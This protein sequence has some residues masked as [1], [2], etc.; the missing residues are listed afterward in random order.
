MKKTIF[1]MAIAIGIGSIAASCGGG[2]NQDLTDS[3]KKLEQDLKKV[4]YIAAD[5]DSVDF[6][7]MIPDYMIS[8]TTLDEGRPFQYMNAY[9]EQYIVCSYEER[10][11]VEPSLKALKPEGKNFLEQYTNYN[12]SIIEENVTITKME[13]VKNLKIDGMPAQ[14]LQFD[15]TVAG[16]AEPISYYTTFIEGKDRIY[17]I[18]AWTLQSKKD[19][20]KDVADKMIG[21]FKVKK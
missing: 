4:N 20:F 7:M 2:G 11:L 6:E 9:K 15:G 3:L 18:M 17:F 13:P 5:N 10:S 1:G 16:I 8:T 14:L 19:D 21:S 12:K